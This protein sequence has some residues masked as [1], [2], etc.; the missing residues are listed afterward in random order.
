VVDILE[1]LVMN[2]SRFKDILHL[3]RMV[4]FFII[5]YKT[6]LD[7]ETKIEGEKCVLNMHIYDN[8]ISCHRRSPLLPPAVSLISYYNTSHTS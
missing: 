1:S 3:K 5:I 2:F 7:I 8:H 4:L 6:H